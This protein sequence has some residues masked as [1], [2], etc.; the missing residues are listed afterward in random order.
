MEIQAE[1]KQ[2]LLLDKN[3]IET[4]RQY[5]TMDP[6]GAAYTGTS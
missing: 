3:S 1:R 6:S 2:Y 5:Y 4:N